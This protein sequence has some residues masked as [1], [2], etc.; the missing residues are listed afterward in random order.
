MTGVRIGDEIENQSIPM[1]TSWRGTD[2]VG[3]RFGPA[4]IAGATVTIVVGLETRIN[5]G[6]DAAISTGEGDR[7]I[8]LTKVHGRGCVGRS[9][10]LSLKENEHKRGVV[11][12]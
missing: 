7:K 3:V 9:E 2:P 1:T 10:V 6:T 8:A 11:R 12:I 4:D 5:D